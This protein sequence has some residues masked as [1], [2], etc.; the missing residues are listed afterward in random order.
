MKNKQITVENTNKRLR[1]KCAMT[2]F[3]DMNQNNFTDKVY[4]LFTTHHS[5][6]FNDT[7][8]SRFT[9]HFSLKAP[10]IQTLHPRTAYLPNLTCNST[11]IYTRQINITSTIA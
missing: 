9:S 7:D 11:F 4:S 6:I 1:N 10:L 5:L 8:F 3:G 2:C